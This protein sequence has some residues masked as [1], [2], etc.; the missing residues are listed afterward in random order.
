MKQSILRRQFPHVRLN[1]TLWLIIF[2]ILIYFVNTLMPSTRYY[3]SLIPALIVG[4]G[5]VW[6]FVTYMFCHAN[7]THILYNM[8]GLFFFGYQLE[9]HLGSYE[10]LLYY[11]LTGVLA[12]VFSFAIYVVT[13]A[14]GVVLLGASGAVFAVLLAF[15][16]YFPDARIFIMG[17][18]P[19]R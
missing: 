4:R 19:V 1:V 13:G 8:L 2:N 12:G 6:Q 7:L 5:F 17:I 9:E 16:T 3:L 15:A 11:L 14:Y 18:I 10:F